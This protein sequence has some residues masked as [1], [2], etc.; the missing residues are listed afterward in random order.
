M[1]CQ[2]KDIFGK[3]GQGVHSIRIFNIAVVDMLLTIVA[4]VLIGKYFKLDAK[5]IVWIFIVLL[6]TSLVVHEALCVETTL[7]KMLCK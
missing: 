1:S 7:T 5:G 3:P 2:Y 6:L 4:A